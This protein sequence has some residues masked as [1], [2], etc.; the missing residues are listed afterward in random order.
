MTELMHDNRKYA[1]SPLPAVSLGFLLGVLGPLLLVERP[2][3]QNLLRALDLI[4][5]GTPLA[6]GNGLRGLP[7]GRMVHGQ[8]T[9][10]AW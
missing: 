5:H 4:P 1:S 3:L 9:E 7:H 2:L 8:P 10:F 6:L